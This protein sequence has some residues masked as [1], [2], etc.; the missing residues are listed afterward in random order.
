MFPRVQFFGIFYRGWIFPLSLEF[1]P[2]AIN[3]LRLTRQFQRAT[4]HARS[5]LGS[6]VRDRA[7]ACWLPASRATISAFP[8]IHNPQAQQLG[9]A[10]RGTYIRRLDITR[11]SCNM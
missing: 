1:C 8:V 2:S 11:Y 10:V 9:E 4:R 6:D 7:L 5:S 3:N